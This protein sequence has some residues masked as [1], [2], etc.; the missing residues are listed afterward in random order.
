MQ[1]YHSLADRLQLIPATAK[2]A[3]GIHFEVRLDR[4]AATASEMITVD[5]KVSG[6]RMDE[7]C[8]CA[9]IGVSCPQVHVQVWPLALS[10][11]LIPQADEHDGPSHRHYVMPHVQGAI[12]PALMRLRDSYVTRARELG[13][14]M[15]S[16]QERRDTGSEVLAERADDNATLEEKVHQGIP[17]LLQYK[18]SLLKTAIS[19]FNARDLL[20]SCMRALCS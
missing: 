16:L 2:R 4:E 3:E 18:F 11:H 15:L 5:L 7:G 20:L 12:K 9:H 14:E 1:D 10:D 8:G 17:R 19:L 6:T 13:V